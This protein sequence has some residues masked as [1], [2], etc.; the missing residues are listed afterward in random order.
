MRDQAAKVEEVLQMFSQI[1]MSA[2]TCNKDVSL[3]KHNTMCTNKIMDSVYVN[4]LDSSSS[5]MIIQLMNS[6]FKKIAYCEN[7][8]E[9]TQYYKQ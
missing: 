6:N 9:F 3:H 8:T 2:I 4:M 7:T 1:C 5:E